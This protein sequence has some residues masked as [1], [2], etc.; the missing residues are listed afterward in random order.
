MANNVI[1]L[2]I[3]MNSFY[4]LIKKNNTRN[5]DNIMEISHKRKDFDPVLY[6]E[7]DYKGKVLATKILSQSKLFKNGT[8]LILDPFEDKQCGDIKIKYFDNSTLNYEIEC[9]GNIRFEKNFNCEYATVNVPMK[10][11]KA[12]PDGFFIVVDESESIEKE[13][14][15]RFY[16]IEVKNILSSEK[17]ANVNKFSK[18]KLEYFY[19]VPSHLVERY[20]W[21]EK[22]GKYKRVNFKHL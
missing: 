2:F 13:I 20:C 6:N 21:N 14:P 18:G 17:A 16:L 4:S 5:K 19:K 7:K 1:K 8:C 15:E 11:F 3:D 10:N 22:A 9:S 12:I